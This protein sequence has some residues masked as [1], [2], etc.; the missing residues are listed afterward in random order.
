MHG[1]GPRLAGRWRRLK[2]RLLLRVLGARHG[3]HQV[4]RAAVGKLAC[5]GELRLVFNRIQ[6][7]ANTTTV[8]LLRELE[9]GQREDPETAKAR[10]AEVPLRLVR[11]R[12]FATLVVIRNPYSRVLSA[13]VQKF[14]AKV[15]KYSERYGEFPVTA[16]GFEAFVEW[17]EQGGLDA[18]THWGLQVEQMYLPL[19]CYDWVIRFEHF[20]DDMAAMLHA[21]GLAVP[22]ARLAPAAGINASQAQ[23]KLR[24]FYTPRAIN[25]VRRVYQRDFEALGYSD[26]F[27]PSERPPVE[28]APSRHPSSGVHSAR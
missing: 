18:N 14:T 19:D 24:S 5:F 13:F 9:C 26:A 12:A 25:I 15:D 20:A 4:R 22:A 8:V 17:I 6:K 27:P 23:E 7:N 1:L 3:A 28:P 2:G 16:A 21:R 10:A 11:P